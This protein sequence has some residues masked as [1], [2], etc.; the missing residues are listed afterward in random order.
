MLAGIQEI[1]LISTP[2]ALPHFYSLLGDGASYGLSISYAE[3]QQPRGIAEALLIAASF[4]GREKVALILGDNLF[5]GEGLATLLQ[6]LEPLDRGALVFGY[7]VHNPE[8]YGVASF[9]EEGKIVDIIEKPVTPPSPYAI[10]GLYFYDSDV[11]EIARGLTPSKRG[12]LE[13]TDVNR[14]YL[15]DCR[16]HIHLFQ[17]GFAWLDAGTFEA[18]HQASNYV[19]AV[20]ARQGIRIG[21]IEEIAY[22]KGWIDSAMLEQLAEKQAKSSYG[23]Y[24]RSLLL[25][26]SS[27]SP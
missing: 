26:I 10:T 18:L 4:I 12:E 6:K 7:R 25:P 17:S 20:Q 11:V 23:E 27:A 16:L 5:Y 24:L 14:I 1:L 3:Q 15:S 2:T 9:N 13:I 21:C 19:E 22:T 8:R